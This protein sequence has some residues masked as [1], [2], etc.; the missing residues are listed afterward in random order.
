M[1]DPRDTLLICTDL[2]RT[3]IP[4]GTQPDTPGSLRLFTDIVH[5]RGVLLAYVTGRNID[6]T[7]QGIT[8]FMLP[9]PA[10]VISDVGASIYVQTD[11][12][13]IRDELW[14][15]CLA[16]DW[17][18]ET[19][20]KIEY[21][22]NQIPQLRLQERE[23]QGRFKISFTA[24]DSA[25]MGCIQKE[26]KQRADETHGPYNII[27]S[28]D[29]GEK[30]HLIDIL[31]RKASKLKALEYLAQS[32]GIPL[33]RTVFSGDSGNDMDVLV[34]PVKGIL[35]AN[36]AQYVKETALGLSER[37]GTLDRIYIAK[38]GP[39]MNGNY[40]AGIIEGL[41]HYFPDR[42]QKTEPTKKR[43]KS[44]E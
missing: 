23:K 31:P 17:T 18:A 4:N 43:R 32:L 12:K 7:L 28:F 34:G 14:D 13:W 26:I 8:E 21:S 5:S 36:A 38:G 35:V 19:R 1:H 40:S 37:S 29:E 24:D 20:K 11:D 41:V 9:T 22:V 27:S 30:R 3:L 2:D 6:Q 15:N 44:Q 16:R 39:G 10:Y 33:S 42:F 25:D